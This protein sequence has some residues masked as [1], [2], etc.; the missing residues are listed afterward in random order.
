MYLDP[1]MAG[2]LL[3][4]AIAVAAVTGAIVFSLRRKAKRVFK[5]DEPVKREKRDDMQHNHII[6]TIGEAD[7]ESADDATPDAGA[8]DSSSGDSGS[9]D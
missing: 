7:N 2:M 9:I 8:S 5:K 6:D 3:Q 1:A 4:I